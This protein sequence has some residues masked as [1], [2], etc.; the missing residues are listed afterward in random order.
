MRLDD[1]FELALVLL[2]ALPVVTAAALVM[3]IS[4]R[5]LL[6]QIEFRVRVLEQAPPSTPAASRPP[7]P[8]APP[9]PAQ[10]APAQV[11]A[12]PPSPPA[13]QSA[14]MSASPP[15]TEPAPARAIG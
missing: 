10:P 9:A 2:L 13:P 4:N 3:A 15:P 7:S 11:A 5:K 1:P 6:R 8:V 12:T 14:A